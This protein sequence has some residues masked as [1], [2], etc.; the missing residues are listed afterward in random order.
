MECGGTA[1][2]KAQRKKVDVVNIFDADASSL[3]L[4][5]A[6]LSH[7]LRLFL[8]RF[9]ALTNEAE[10]KLSFIQFMQQVQAGLRDLSQTTK[11]S[12]RLLG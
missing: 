3:G 8:P 9:S 12:P 4:S 10:R 6:G 1:K 5:V 2:G 7:K 11:T